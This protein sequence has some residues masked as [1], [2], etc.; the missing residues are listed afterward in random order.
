MAFSETVQLI[1]STTST[2]SSASAA[3]GT[4][5]SQAGQY[6]RGTFVLVTSGGTGSGSFT[7]DVAIQG[8]IAGSWTDVGRFAQ[9]TTSGVTRVLWDVC[10]TV[11]SSSTI[12]EASQDLAITVSTKRAGPWG[13]QIRATYTL[14]ITGT[15]SITWYV[16]GVLQS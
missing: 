11:S 10:G 8:Y 15:Y 2:S 14:T 4:A 16:S 12:E 13:S 9:V 1:S 5:F 6:R 7:L 3:D